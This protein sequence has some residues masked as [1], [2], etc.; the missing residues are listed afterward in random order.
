MATHNMYVQIDFDEDIKKFICKSDGLTDIVATLNVGDV[1]TIVHQGTNVLGTVQYSET[2]QPYGYYFLSND[3]R[4]TLELND[5]MYGYVERIVKD[6]S[7]YFGAEKETVNK[8]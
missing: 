8:F 5:G 1:F 6:G 4:L 3:D 7:F 2:C